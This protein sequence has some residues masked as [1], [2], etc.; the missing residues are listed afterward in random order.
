[1]VR[2]IQFA[3]RAMRPLPLLRM[4]PILRN[5]SKIMFALLMPVYRRAFIVSAKVCSTINQIL[6]I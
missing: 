1:M 6:L 3:S 4:K 2:A 5:M